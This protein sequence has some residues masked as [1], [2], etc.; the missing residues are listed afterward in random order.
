MGRLPGTQKG[1]VP[2]VGSV[3]CSDDKRKEVAAFFEPRLKDM[4]GAPRNLAGTLEAIEL[5]QA[6]VEVHNENAI[7]YFAGER[8]AK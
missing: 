1:Y 2:W 5:C 7:T 4:P 6:R 3:F 8:R